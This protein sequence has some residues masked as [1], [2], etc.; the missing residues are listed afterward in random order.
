ME[1]ITLLASLSPYRSRFMIR[2]L[3]KVKEIFESDLNIKVNL[4]ITEGN[5]GKNLIFIESD[6]IEISDNIRTADLVEE[7]LERLGSYRSIIPLDKVA[8]G[9]KV[10]ESD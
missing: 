4:V 9:M 8:V 1:E 3:N 2:R 5:N 6:V 7:I 10:S